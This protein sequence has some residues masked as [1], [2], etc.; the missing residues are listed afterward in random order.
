MLQKLRV[1]FLPPAFTIKIAEC[2]LQFETCTVSGCQS[3]HRVSCRLVFM[4]PSSFQPAVRG[5]PVALAPLSCSFDDAL[6]FIGR[7]ATSPTAETRGSFAAPSRH[8]CGNLHDILNLYLYALYPNISH[9]VMS[10]M[11][12]TAY[13]HQRPWAAP[14]LL[15]IASIGPHPWRPV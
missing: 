6:R 8:R 5:I 9:P 12:L 11:T 10:S 3:K 14:Q 13:K 4:D 15:E 1:I 7:L 2:Y